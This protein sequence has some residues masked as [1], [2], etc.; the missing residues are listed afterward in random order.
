MN[1]TQRNHIL[2]RLKSIRRRRSEEYEKS[3]IK[4]E[5]PQR[6]TLGVL[7]DGI[8]DGSIKANG[9]R[10]RKLVP[11][12]DLEDVFN[13][14]KFDEDH[15]VDKVYDKVDAFEKKLDAEIER[16][17]DQLYLG[18]AEDALQMIAAFEKFEVK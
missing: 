9:G 6:L 14:K 16:I 5:Q 7:L 17:E 1:Q 12:M 10:T 18:D 2:K 3:L 13:L 4:K 15:I 11:W 8:T